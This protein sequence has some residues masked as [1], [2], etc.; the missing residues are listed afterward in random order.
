M[1]KFKRAMLVLAIVVTLFSVANAV[2]KETILAEFGDSKITYEDLEK[3]IESIPAMYRNSYTTEDGMK[4]LLD[5]YCTES[6]F[7]L[8]SWKHDIDGN[9]GY[10]G[11]LI[12]QLRSVYHNAYKSS[13][14]GEIVLTDAEKKAFFEEHPELFAGRTFQESLGQIEN[15]LMP[16]KQ[17]EI[18]QLKKAELMEK[19]DVKIIDENVQNFNIEDLDANIPN[20]EKAVIESSNPEL[21]K[22]V[23]DLVELYKI[24]PQN[25]KIAIKDD[26]IL[27]KY[28]DSLIEL[29]LFYLEALEMG[30]GEDEALLAQTELVKKQLRLSATYN[31]IV[32]DK[33]DLSDENVKKYYDEN[34][35]QFSTKATRKIQ[36]FGF[37]NE[38]VATEI[39]AK[40]QKQI[41]LS[42]FENFQNA[43]KVKAKKQQNLQKIIEEYS[44][45]KA[46]N[47]EIDHIYQND[48][49]PGIGKD[50]KYCDL[51][52]NATVDSTKLSE[53]F[54]NVK[55][56]FVFFRI[57]NDNQAIPQPFA[58]VEMKVKS[59]MQKKLT[60]KKFEDVTAELETKYNL[61]K[62]QERLLIIL[63]VKEYYD[64]AEAS[65]KGRRFEDALH[66]YDKIIQF[67][68]N[69]EDDYKATFMKGFIYTENL[70]D[71]EKAAEF[72]LKVLE[73]PK[74]DLHE[75]AQFMLDEI[76][77]KKTIEFIEE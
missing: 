6:L 62:Y 32:A 59:Q 55:G 5:M 42:F 24:L 38:K 53:I 1:I 39:R 17:N 51:V 33:I 76:S 23:A 75:S 15:K 14:A 67:Y 11:R 54:Q 56:E 37:E 13:F 65:Q 10:R 45:Y 26:I 12:N 57:L 18:I 9:N 43:E 36:T 47:G 72:F 50:K 28:L 58:E 71:N 61:K 60:K 34:I 25:K 70:K 21:H 68:Q 7:Y 35:V 63:D 41:K 19:Y 52:W 49:I 77:G 40:V 66:Y 20:N 73:F 16:Q 2:P 29:D 3:K 27:K 64:K 69:D 31:I 22:T 44:I 74:G 48:I 8:E 46:K 30:F 4:R